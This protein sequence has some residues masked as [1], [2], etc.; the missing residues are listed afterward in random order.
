[1]SSTNIKK[2]LSEPRLNRYE[3]VT[4]KGQ[5]LDTEHALKLYS[6]NAQVSAAFF[7][8][9][10]LCEVVIR[11][12]IAEALEVK[13]GAN[14]PWVAAFEHSL[15]DPARGYSPRKDLISARSKSGATT[16]GKVIPELKFVFWEKL[17]TARFDGRLWDDHLFSVFP[18]ACSSDSVSTVRNR[19]RSL[20][21]NVRGLRNRIAHHEPILSR[22]LAN[23]F[24]YI[25][26]LIKHRCTDTAAWAM[27]NQMVTPLMDLRPF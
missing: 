7:A 21:E 13:Y 22:N 18:N 27:K 16:T 17:L 14:W 19:L 24:Q 15:P 12:A 20:L 4:F 3:S 10:H 5:A 11:N 23:D 26:S 25:E 8:P 6:W 2:A 9:L 1:M